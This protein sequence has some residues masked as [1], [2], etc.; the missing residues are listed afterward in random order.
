MPWHLVSLPPGTREVRLAVK[1]SYRLAGIQ[2]V[3]QVGERAELVE[4]MVRTDTPKLVMGAL[5]VLLGLLGAALLPRRLGFAFALYTVS[6]GVFSIYYSDLKQL[7]LP[8]RNDV[9]FFLWL[10]AVA[11]VPI[12]YLRFTNAVFETP[13]RLGPA[14]QR[15]HQVWGALYL[16]VCVVAWVA[17]TRWGLEA[18]RF[19]SPALFALGAVLRVMMVVS[20]LVSLVHMA[21]LARR[22][23]PDR[24]N[25]RVLLVAFV[26]VAAA[27]VANIG[28]AL[29]LLPSMRGAY[30]T[31]GLFAL[32]LGLT[33]VAQRSWART[34]LQLSD[35]VKEK[36]A[37]LRDLHD[38][39]GGVTTN[40][41][42][43]A[44]LGKRDSQKAIEALSAISELSNEGLAEL[45]AFTQTLDEAEAQVTW[46]IFCSELR[47][48][49]G[50]LIEA[51]G[52]AFSL[53]ARLDGEGRP[54]SALVLTVLRI[55]REALTNVVKHAGATR[56]D[57]TVSVTRGTLS[58]S[59]SD[60]G[61]G[62]GPGGG[63]DTGR[64]VANMKARARDLGGELTVAT[65]AGTRLSL[66]LLRPS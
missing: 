27:M 11:G 44:E 49:G 60:D 52:K 58:L 34:R 39:I 65:G 46:P 51:H 43:L 54:G 14:L 50:Q 19:A 64:G 36:E 22:E 32:A 41:R 28:A 10:A 42:L 33:V 13:P 8:L 29:G 25:A 35:R 57:V 5:M 3:P 21:Q 37:M 31:P 59:I 47:R 40:I 53:E 18:E 26:A 38:G 61:A 20:A 55:F 7:V 62:G 15:A 4:R 30:V 2:A 24:E 56:V 1:T 48:F 63:L 9:W 23:G 12:G 45:R 66:E 17:M 16:G 6:S